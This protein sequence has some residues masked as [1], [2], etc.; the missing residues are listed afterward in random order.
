MIVIP[1][2]N[3][4]KTG[5]NSYYVKIDRL[6]EHYQGIADSGCFH[7]KSPSSEGAVYFDDE[8]LINAIF[9]KNKTNVIKGKEAI[10]IIMAET[11]SN[12]FSVSIYEIIPERIIYWA[13]LADAE[14]LHKDLSTEFT[15]LEGLIKK[16]ISEKLTG[17][18]EVA[19]SG[20]DKAVLFLFNGEILGSASSDN[21][22]KL[23]TTDGLP[24]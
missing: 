11:F 17:Y 16:K 5:L 22:W 12:N 10:D 9:L 13:N 18:I 6:F 23:I 15:D 4:L 21:K 19:C 7:F 14:D 20:K 24:T 3:P 8:N 2:E 1:R